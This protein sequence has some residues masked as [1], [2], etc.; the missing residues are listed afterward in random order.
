MVA[1]DPACKMEIN[2]KTAKFKTE[3][4]GEAYYFSASG[5]KIGRLREPKRICFVIWND[6]VEICTSNRPTQSPEGLNH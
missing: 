4:K 3:H 2:E 5:C 1:I 6:A